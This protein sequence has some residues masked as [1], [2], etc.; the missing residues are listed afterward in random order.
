MKTILLNK[1]QYPRLLLEI[2]KPPKTLYC[3]GSL[4][5]SQ[6]EFRYLCVVGA[7][8]YSKYG[9]DV[10]VRLIRRLK[11]YPIVIVSGL[12]IGIDSIAHAEA[13][14]VGMRVIGI[15]G[16]GLS[17]EVLYPRTRLSLADKMIREG[18]TLLSPFEYEQGATMWTFPVR[19]CLMAGISHATL[20]IEGRHDSG[21]LITAKHALEF[22]RDVL[23]VPGSIF[24]DL[25]VG[26]HNL[27]KEG[28]IPVFSA[29]DILDALG[30]DIP[31]NSMKKDDAQTEIIIPASLSDEQKKILQILRY[32]P[33]NSSELLDKIQIS[34]P[35]LNIEISQLELLDLVTEDEG[36]YRINTSI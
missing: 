31:K 12:A 9:H 28:A 33:Q 16:S 15:P 10:C 5:P 26:P 29:K 30:F 13:L 17:R 1:S 8:N 23:V 14:K 3:A 21:T 7:R 34:S 11:D 25:S 19:N 22:N 27:F 6:E 36:K 18:Q 2:D 20:I 24:S 4:P 35:A 32:A